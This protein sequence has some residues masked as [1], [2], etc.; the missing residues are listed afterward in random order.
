MMLHLA[1]C[2]LYDSSTSCMQ[3]AR[4]LASAEAMSDARRVTLLEG[5]AGCVALQAWLH[6][7]RDERGKE[8]ECVRR[9]GHLGER[10]ASLPDGECEVLYG[11]CGF[12]GAVLFLRQRLCD[13]VLLAEPA[14]KL[15]RQVVSSGRRNARE[16]WPLYFEWHEKCYLGGAHGIAG[17]LNTL[18][19]LPTEVAEAGPEV[20]D[21]IR[22]CADKLLDGRFVSGNLPSSLG[23]GKD[24]LVQF[25]HGATGAVPLILRLA[26]VY[27][28]PRY[29]RE[30]KELGQVIWRRGLLS[31]K[32]L[33]LCHGIP[34]NG[35]ALLGIYKQTRDEVWLNR[36]I[37]FAVF[38]CEHQVLAQQ[39][40]R[41]H[42][43][44]E[45]LAGA[46]CF[47]GSVLA[48]ATG[49]ATTAGFPCYDF[50]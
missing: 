45:G 2:G 39:A 28:E 40:D 10:A 14:A 22:G 44:F 26:K 1:A 33:G 37:H 17:I 49:D 18:L 47:W 46:A 36:A 4:V 9:L 32:G 43:L 31:T 29:L 23:S 7:L 5:L 13:P 41:P 24:R 16:G 27:E 8:E 12:L 19:Q 50:D 21:L 15:V 3:S 42:S 30:A 20:A 35:F 25:C 48:A 11:R 6:R 38:A 34:G